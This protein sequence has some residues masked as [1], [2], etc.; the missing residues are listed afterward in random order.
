MPEFLLDSIRYQ[1]IHHGTDA[2]GVQVSGLIFGFRLEPDPQR[3]HLLAQR[4]PVRVQLAKLLL[5]RS[6]G[7]V[8]SHDLLG[9]I[10]KLLK[11]CICVNAWQR[12]PQLPGRFFIFVRRI[13]F[14]INRPDDV[15]GVKAVQPHQKRGNLPALFIGEVV[16]KLKSLRVFFGTQRTGNAVIQPPG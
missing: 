4:S 8:I 9:Q 13:L 6:Y 3:V 16:D 2:R 5:G 14:R 15:L 1:V 10:V 11:K 12:F 7:I